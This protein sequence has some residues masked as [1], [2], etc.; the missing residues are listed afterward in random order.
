M[1]YFPTY[2]P[3]GAV[4]EEA[5]MERQEKRA[6]DQLAL[7]RERLDIEREG[8]AEKIQVSLASVMPRVEP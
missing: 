6:D 4:D 2:R 7:E 3:V 8:H 1:S 5:L